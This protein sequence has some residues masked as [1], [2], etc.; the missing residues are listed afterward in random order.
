MLCESTLD[1]IGLK[2]INYLRHSGLIENLPRYI[3]REITY[4]YWDKSNLNYNKPIIHIPLSTLSKEI[5]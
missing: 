2:K 3:K 1:I 5:I 4:R